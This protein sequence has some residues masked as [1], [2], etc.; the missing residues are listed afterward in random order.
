MVLAPRAI[1]RMARKPNRRQD[2]ARDRDSSVERLLWVAFLAQLLF[3]PQV[4][5]AYAAGAYDGEWIGSATGTPVGRCRPTNVVVTVAGNEA[6]G[7]ATFDGDLRNIRGTVRPDGTLG[8]TIGFQQLTG[9]F[10]EDR[11]EGIFSSLD[12]KWNVVLR[13][14]RRP[15]SA[16]PAR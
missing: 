5:D 4:G 13:R 10:T 16:A 2:Q 11:F 3:V 6:E 7:K 12:C 1:T 14:S 9:M 15:A 8:A